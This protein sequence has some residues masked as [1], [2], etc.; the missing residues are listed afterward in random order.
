MY[1]SIESMPKSTV[2][3]SLHVSPNKFKFQMWMLHILGYKGLSIRKLKPYLYGEKKGKVVGITFDDGYQNNLTNAAPVLSKY[4]FSAT[5][6]IVS[7]RIG[8]FNTWDLNK[9]ITQR[10]LMTKNEIN[11]WLEL[12]MDIGGH[13]KTHKD[14]TKISIKEAQKEI[15][16]CKNSLEETFNIS[17]TDFCYPFGCFDDM[18]SAM[19][20]D[21]GFLSATTMTR[22]RASSKSNMFRLPRIPVN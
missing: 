7:E 2:M 21:S 20:K 10:P 8:C 13:T 11:Q 16:D 6:Y 3:R 18:V 4:N 17:I 9:K 5:C 1:H 14:L 19:V 22:G 15:R 12:G